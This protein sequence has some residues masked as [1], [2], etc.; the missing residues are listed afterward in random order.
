M[1]SSEKAHASDLLWL[2]SALIERKTRIQVH[3][4]IAALDQFFQALGEA[5]RRSAIDQS[6][7]KANRQAQVFPDSD[8]SVHDPRLLANATHCNSECWFG[9]RHAP[10]GTFPKHTH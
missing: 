1:S 5:S 4:A 10:A 6:V 2:G 9:W 7:I 8:L 3:Q